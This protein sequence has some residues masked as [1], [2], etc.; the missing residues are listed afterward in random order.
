MPDEFV[1][2]CINKDYLT[3]PYLYCFP[4]SVEKN[5]VFMS[6]CFDSTGDIAQLNF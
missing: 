3:L 5:F 4:S 2:P 6:K 1:T